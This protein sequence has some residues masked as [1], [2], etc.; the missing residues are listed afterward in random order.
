MLSVS[1]SLLLCEHMLLWRLGFWF[2]Q[3]GNEERK[4]NLLNSNVFCD[5]EIAPLF[6]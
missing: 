5:F 2:S 4:M 3:L 1:G 6:S